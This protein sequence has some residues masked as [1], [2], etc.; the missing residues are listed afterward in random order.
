LKKYYIITLLFLSLLYISCEEFILG[1][2]P[3]NT[4]ENNFDILWRE[5]DLYYPSFIIKGIDWDSLYTV[6]RTQI[7][8]QTT[9]N[10]LWFIMRSLLRNLDD[11]HVEMYDAN[12]RYFLS[13]HTYYDENKFSLPLIKYKYL[14]NKFNTAG[15]GNYTY[16][17]LGR[18]SIGYLY[19]GTFFGDISWTYDIDNIVSE[20]SDVK[21]MI[22]DL[23]DNSGGYTSNLKNVA[24]AFV[25]SSVTYSQTIARNGPNHNDFT[26]PFFNKVIPRLNS[27]H[28]TKRIIVLT[29]GETASASESFSLFFK[30]LPY[31]EQIGVSTA[32]GLGRIRGFQLP[33]GW[34]YHMSTSLDLTVEGNSLENIGVSPDIYV[35]NTEAEIES[36]FDRQLEFTLQYLSKG[37]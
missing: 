26:P 18:D 6:Y 5:F 21:V 29:N 24:S 1:P 12:G 23:R 11:L 28:F 14:K 2:D 19:I 31:S 13:S 8:S 16:G 15:G 20:L 30:Q 35:E 36:G 9:D 34:L 22:V 25:T 4:P 32:G 27:P 10:D 33:N 3:E 17:R 37:K 7:T